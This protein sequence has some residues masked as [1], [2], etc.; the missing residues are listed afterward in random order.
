M[1]CLQDQEALSHEFYAL[2]TTVY[3]GITEDLGDVDVDNI[4]DVV[5]DAI[6]KN[7]DRVFAPTSLAAAVF[8]RATID[9]VSGMISASIKAYLE[10]TDDE[11]CVAEFAKSVLAHAMLSGT[12]CAFASGDAFERFCEVH[13]HAA[14]L[15]HAWRRCIADPSFRA[16]R[17][18][19]AREAAELCIST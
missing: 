18:R 6:V 10:H 4:D 12:R 7:V 14:M 5:Y 17:D 8:P 2:L 15:Q 1:P 16:C 19:L 11:E 3:Q 13:E 9:T